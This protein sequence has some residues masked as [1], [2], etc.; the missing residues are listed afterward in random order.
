MKISIVTAVRNGRATIADSLRSVATQTFGDREHIVIDGLS[1]DGTQQV[2][3]ERRDT[4]DVYLSQAD[5]GIYN[6]LNKGLQ[7]CTGDVVGFLHSDDL[8]AS[9]DVLSK[10]AQAFADPHVDVV[11]GDLLYVSKDV[12]KSIRHW[13]AGPFSRGKL[14]RGWMPPHPT[15]YVRRQIYS[16]LGGFNETF[17]I[18]ADYDCI[19][20]M[21]GHREL[22]ATYIPEVLVKM[23]VGGVSNSSLGNI[24]RKSAEDYRALRENRIGGLATL[25]AKNIRKVGQFVSAP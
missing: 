4:I 15:L 22:R 23:R 6:A 12:S 5:T 18:A 2:I 1:T 20:R 16:Q 9:D 14:A 8:L 21:F 25:F 3:E 7:L 24:W 17:R 11:Y 10:V 13:R 19:L